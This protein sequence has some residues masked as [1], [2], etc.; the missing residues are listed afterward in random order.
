VENSNVQVLGFAWGGCPFNVI[1]SCN[2]RSSSPPP[3]EVRILYEMF[4]ALR[5][6]VFR[7]LLMNKFFWDMKLF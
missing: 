4:C 7:V 2:I 3:S 5:F 1:T 6:E